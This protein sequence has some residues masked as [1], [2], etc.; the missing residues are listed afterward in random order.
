VSQDGIIR[1]TRACHYH[2][3]AAAPLPLL[4]FSPSLERRARAITIS[5]PLRHYRRC[6]TTI[7]SPLHHYHFIAAAPLPFHRRLTT[8]SSSFRGQWYNNV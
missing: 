8:I 3:I 1:E 2:F 7:S 4:L 5:S 6:A